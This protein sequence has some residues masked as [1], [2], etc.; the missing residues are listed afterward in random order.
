MSLTDESIQV[1]NLE[2]PE[3]PRFLN[4]DNARRIVEDEDGLEQEAGVYRRIMKHMHE[5][6]QEIRGDSY[7]RQCCFRTEKDD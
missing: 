2:N 4:L 3:A 6:R 7:R 5:L 1:Y